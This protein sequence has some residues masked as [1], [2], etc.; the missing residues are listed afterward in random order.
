MSSSSVVAKVYSLLNKLPNSFA[1][2]RKSG[3]VELSL[4][5]MSLKTDITIDGRSKGQLYGYCGLKKFGI[6][7]NLICFCPLHLHVNKE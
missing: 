1:E 3:I 6:V 4:F 7:V 2:D 5:R